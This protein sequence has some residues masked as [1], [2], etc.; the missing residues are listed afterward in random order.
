MV[1]YSYVRADS[2]HHFLTHSFNLYLVTDVESDEEGL[3]LGPSVF[4]QA[5]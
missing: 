2:I 5:C 4:G 1:K 3:G